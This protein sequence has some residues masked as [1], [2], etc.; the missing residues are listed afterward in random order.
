MAKYTIGIYH[1]E[2]YRSAVVVDAKNLDDAIAIVEREW[3][4]KKNPQIIQE[5]IDTPYDCET[6]F[7]KEG[8]SCEYDIEHLLNIE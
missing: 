4:E 8:R 5:T 2:Y 1:V 6:H 3:W 7:M